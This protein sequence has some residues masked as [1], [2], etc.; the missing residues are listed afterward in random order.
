MLLGATK[1]WSISSQLACHSAAPSRVAPFET[2]SEAGKRRH[3]SP[4][5]AHGNSARVS[6]EYCEGVAGSQTVDS[7][8]PRDRCAADHLESLHF[9]ILSHLRVMIGRS[10]RHLT[11]LSTYGGAGRRRRPI[12]AGG[13]V[14]VTSGVSLM[15]R[16]PGA[17]WMRPEAIKW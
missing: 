7:G 14:K 12:Y 6:F 8:R 9:R 10:A 4:P 16:P 17:P 13:V 2:D 3:P 5:Q 15:K 1:A 11:S